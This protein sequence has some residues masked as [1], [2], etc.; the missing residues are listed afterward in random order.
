[1]GNRLSLA[2]RQKEKIMKT[3]T[4]ELQQWSLFART[5][6]Y[7]EEEK[8]V[9]WIE[10]NGIP[11][12]AWTEETMRNIA[13]EWGEFLACT[14]ETLRMENMD[15]ANIMIWSC[16]RIMEKTIKSI[17]VNK[18]LYQVQIKEVNGD[19]IVCFLEQ[20]EIWPTDNPNL[21]F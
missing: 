20:P 15:R 9:M 5:N 21:N 10:C 1:M 3:L 14:N 18:E 2:C 6:K 12:K 4:K 11:V 16:K 17:R 7:D 19:D 13:I 8:R